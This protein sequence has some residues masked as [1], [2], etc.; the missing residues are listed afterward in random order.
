MAD[1]KKIGKSQRSYFGL[2]MGV[3]SIIV[4]AI[5][6]Y[7]LFCWTIN[8]K[9]ILVHYI[10]G[11]SDHTD[12]SGNIGLGFWSINILWHTAGDELFNVTR[13][14]NGAGIFT[15]VLFALYIIASG[16]YLYLNKK[17][18]IET[19]FNFGALICVTLGLCAIVFII[20]MASL[21]DVNA[22]RTWLGML[23]DDDV[24]SNIPDLIPLPW[25][26]NLGFNAVSW[27][28]SGGFS[29]TVTAHVSTLAT[30][31]MATIIGAEFVGIFPAIK[32]VVEFIRK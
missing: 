13:V 14:L 7:L 4:F 31:V 1:N 21:P 25:L 6:T 22:I 12:V 9:G 11:Q 30:I 2:V 26:W 16:V 23:K 17:N 20:G 24:Q 29:A 5:M 15:I 27:T 3:S 28:Q 32:G 8:G 19:N 10:D 18:T